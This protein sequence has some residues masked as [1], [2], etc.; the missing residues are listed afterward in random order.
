MILAEAEVSIAR[1]FTEAADIYKVSESSLQLRAM[2]MIYEGIR[3]NNSMM[4]MPT[5][6]MDSMDMGTALASA[7][8]KKTTEQHREESHDN[9]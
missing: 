6:L 7:A 5:S 9:D 2:N 3:Q 1:K 8:L 4:L